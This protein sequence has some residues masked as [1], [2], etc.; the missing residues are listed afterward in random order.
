MVS[1]VGVTL[2]GRGIVVGIGSVEVWKCGSVSGG[3]S[4]EVCGGVEVWV[5]VT[6]RV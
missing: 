3:V 4:V 5:G 6:G 2:S 1:E